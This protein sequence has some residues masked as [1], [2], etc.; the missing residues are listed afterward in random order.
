MTISE[1]IVF[2]A[3]NLTGAAFQNMMQDA[4]KTDADQEI[5]ELKGL[6]SYFKKFHL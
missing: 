2:V 1:N 5:E 3:K 4:I 6:D